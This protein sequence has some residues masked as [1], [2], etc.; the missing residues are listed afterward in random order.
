MRNYKIVLY[1]NCGI[2]IKFIIIIIIIDNF[3]WLLFYFLAVRQ[4]R[5]RGGRN[6]FGPMYKRDRA[7]KQQALRA[8]QRVMA[9]C[10]SG[11]QVRHPSFN[12]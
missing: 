7:M 3:L 12:F 2:Q 6:K 10:E 4:D 9:D 1:L 11:L 5:M 8:Q